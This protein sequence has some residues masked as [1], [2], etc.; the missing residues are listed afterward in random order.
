MARERMVTRTICT[1]VITAK[2]YNSKDDRLETV[3]FTLTGFDTEQEAINQARR[4]SAREGLTFLKV[5]KVDTDKQ[6]YGMKEV[7][8]LKYAVPMNY[9]DSK[10]PTK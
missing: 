6:L 7:D 2:V 3:T 5:I 8:F 1:S 4:E 10:V 9:G